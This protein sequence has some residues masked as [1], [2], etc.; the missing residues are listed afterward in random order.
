MRCALFIAG[1]AACHADP[2]PTPPP[3]CAEVADHMRARKAA[4]DTDPVILAQT[5]DV[6]A[7]RCTAD[8]WSIE[9]MTCITGELGG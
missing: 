1:L 2:A 7:Q 6:F 9:V 5:H 3:T 4:H 8:A